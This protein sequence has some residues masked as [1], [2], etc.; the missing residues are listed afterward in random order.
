[1]GDV[2]LGRGSG[3]R[4]PPHPQVLQD[5]AC[6]PPERCR[7]VLAPAVPWALNLSKEEQEQEH[8]PGSLLRHRCNSWWV[9]PAPRNPPRPT[10]GGA[11]VRVGSEPC[12]VPSVCVRGTFNCSQED[13]SGERT[14]SVPVPLPVPWS[15]CHSRAL[16]VS[17]PPAVDCLWSP[18]S[19]WSPCSVTCGAGERLSRRHPLRQRLYEGAEC[20]GPPLR[21]APCSLPDCACPEGERWQDPG[22]QGPGVPP[23]CD[24]S[25]T[26]IPG[27]A[28]PGCSTAPAPGCACE[29]GRYRNSSGRC[30]PAALCECLHR[31]Q[32]HQPGSEWQEECA[33]CRC[34]E[35]RAACTDG[36][37]PLSCPEVQPQPPPAA[38]QQPPPGLQERLMPLS[39]QGE[40][41]VKEPGRCCPV[42]RMEWPEEPSSMCR[43]FTELRNITKGPCSLPGVQVS[44]CS[45]RCRSRTA[46]TPERGDG[47]AVQEP[48]LQTLCECCSYRLDPASPVRI[49]SLPCAGGTAEPVV[50]PVI[51]SCECSSCQG[52]DF[53][54]R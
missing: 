45:G 36:C 40:V 50:L 43:L 29:P 51:H 15:P 18:W 46:V 31:G 41:K 1:M 24:Q 30:V 49:L 11:G 52:G 19:P 25:C 42:C 13:C 4:V 48:Y 54:K 3:L 28:P 33:R 16:L 37:P 27:E 2:G 47:V 35:G 44:F 5:G 10:L 6:V 17:P 14:P 32:I 38:P 9:P 39:L 12:S 8:A 22:V 23:G 26:D 20:L 53:S 34:V 21:R 7:C